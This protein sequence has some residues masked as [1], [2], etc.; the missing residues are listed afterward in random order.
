MD[1]PY[2]SDR[3]RMVEDQ[4]RGRGIRDERILDSMVRIPRQLF[5]PPDYE[6][7][8]YGDGPLPIGEGQTISQPFIVALM[9][10]LLAL[11]EDMTVLEIG[12]GSG[13]QAAI[14][15]SLV[16]Q[17]YTIERFQS[18]A[19]RAIIAFR[20]LKLQ[21]IRVFTGDGS[22]G[23]PEFAPFDAMVFTAAA[24]RVPKKIENQLAE[25]GCLV[26]PVGGVRGQVLE[27]W[28]KKE[29]RFSREQL[30]P[31]AFVPLRGKFGWTKQDWDY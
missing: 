14:L 25:G 21:N 10:Q 22:Q 31:V 26:V 4:L 19:D 7:L 23:L 8:A 15:S 2:L 29:G 30:V 1:D 3:L 18:L 5:V 16:K 13:Y 11:K 24:P 12:T 28:T 20:E 27:R 6:H 17:V 9:T